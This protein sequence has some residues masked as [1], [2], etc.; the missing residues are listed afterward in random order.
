MYLVTNS[1][2]DKT[3]RVDINTDEFRKLY[4]D[5]CAKVMNKKTIDKDVVSAIKTEVTAAFT[6]DGIAVQQ[7]FDVVDAKFEYV[8]PKTCDEAVM[9]MRAAFIDGSFKNVEVVVKDIPLIDRVQVRLASYIMT[10]L[11]VCSAG[12]YAYK[13]FKGTEVTHIAVKI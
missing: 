3:I 1:F 5:S 2:D 13:Y 7:P 8:D 4:V 11:F 9:R 12:R 6:K 10:T